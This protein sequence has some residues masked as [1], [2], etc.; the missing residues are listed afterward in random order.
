VADSSTNP[1][2][3][4]SAPG[5]F[6][7]PIPPPD[8]RR[9]VGPIDPAAFDNPDGRPVFGAAVPLS[10][11]ESI[12]DFGCGCGRL[13][14]RLI[15]QTTPPRRYRGVDP[16]RQMVD[17]C[18]ANL[19]PHA[20]GFTFSHHD[21]FQEFMNPG[22]SLTAVP[23]PVEDQSVTLFVAWSVFT[24]LFQ[25]DAEYYL[26]E[27]A[28]VLRPSGVAVT[29]WFL[30]DKRDFPMMQAFQNT[31]FISDFDPTNAIIF[32]RGWLTTE[33]ARDGLVIRSIEPPAI[34]G[35]QWTL[36]LSHRDSGS[37][38]VDFPEDLA[39]RGISRPPAG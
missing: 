17:W 34:R 11:Y 6:A 2:A 15:Q 3:T 25:Q 29:T 22:G 28:R 13:A 30:F 18:A 38:G 10:A 35:Y 32:D 5:A 12:F 23:L 21:V 33:L 27:I 20:P 26:R 4:P 9:L 36:Y 39:P 8:L 14:R 7:L 19:S 31:L 24:H 1:Q 37:E 16:N